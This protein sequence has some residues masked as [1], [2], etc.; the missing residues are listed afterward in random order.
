MVCP[1]SHPSSFGSCALGGVKAVFS[2]RVRGLPI[3]LLTQVTLVGRCGPLIL[4]GP[5]A[6]F[7]VCPGLIVLLVV[8][9][10]YWSKFLCPCSPGRPLG[11]C[12]LRLFVFWAGLALSV[13]SPHNTYPCRIVF[14]TLFHL[15]HS[16]GRSR[17]LIFL[18]FTYMLF[19]ECFVT[20]LFGIQSMC[21]YKIR[22]TRALGQLLC[23]FWDL[24]ETLGIF[25]VSCMCVR[26]R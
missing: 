6:T 11:P 13:V 20:A 3:F 17:P 21:R 5:S 22:V 16:S 26:F 2:S 7:L 19:L 23:W 1:C 15:Q 10:P 9:W 18:F 4:A 24:V 8:L 14:D 25:H 12:F